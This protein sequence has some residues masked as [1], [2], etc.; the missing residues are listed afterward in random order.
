MNGANFATKITEIVKN[1]EDQ[2]KVLDKINNGRS[3]ES[4]SKEERA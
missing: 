3:H 1:Q 2:M 4:F